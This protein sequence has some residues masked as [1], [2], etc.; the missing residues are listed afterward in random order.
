ME[1]STSQFKEKKIRRKG[2]EKKSW[3]GSI[4]KLFSALTVRGINRDLK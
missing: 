4:Q 2:R 1:F 3:E